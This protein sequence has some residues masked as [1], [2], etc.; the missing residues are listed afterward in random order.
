M[1]KLCVWG[2]GKGGSGVLLK[3]AHFQQ[4][5]LHAVLTHDV[6]S[7]HFL[8]SSEHTV[9]TT[10]KK[11]QR[12]TGI[13]IERRKNRRNS[14]QSCALNRSGSCDSCAPAS[15]SHSAIPMQMHNKPIHR[16]AIAKSESSGLLRNRDI[17]YCTEYGS[18]RDYNLFNVNLPLAVGSMLH[19]HQQS[20]L[21]V[22]SSPLIF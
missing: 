21:A 1:S 10:T 2:C 22:V 20:S 5:T 7:R 12:N 19:R 4:N 18:L 8:H 14:Q 15:V 13:I 16:T 6:Q 9:C 17:Q 3:V 11:T